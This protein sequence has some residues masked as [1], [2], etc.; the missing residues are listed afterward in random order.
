MN[1]LAVSDRRELEFIS[2]NFVYWAELNLLLMFVVLLQFAAFLIQSW[3]I[4]CLL[5]GRMQQNAPKLCS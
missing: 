3:E 5:R 4:W 2:A 1:E